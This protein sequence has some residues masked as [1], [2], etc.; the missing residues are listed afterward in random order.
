MRH[1]D[2]RAPLGVSH[3]DGAVTL[4]LVSRRRF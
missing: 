4:A 2:G 1:D 3:Q